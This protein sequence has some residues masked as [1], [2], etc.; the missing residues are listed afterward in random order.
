[1]SIITPRNGSLGMSKVI[2]DMQ[3][4][5][6]IHSLGAMNTSLRGNLRIDD[7][8]WLKFVARTSTGLPAIHAERSIDS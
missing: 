5:V 4:A 1:M 2:P 6:K 7:S 3:Q 8:G